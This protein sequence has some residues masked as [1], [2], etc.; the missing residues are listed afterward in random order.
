MM[1]VFVCS[2]IGIDIKD[3]DFRWTNDLSKERNPRLVNVNLT[4]SETELISVIGPVG[5][6]KST[7][8]HGI[9]GELTRPK[10]ELGIGGK[11]AYVPQQAFIINA[12][13]RDNILFGQPYIPLKYAYVIKACALQA[14]LDLFD[15]GDMTEIGE[16]GIN[17]SGGQ[18]QRISLARA[19]YDD[20]A[21]IILLDDPLSAVDAHVARH[22]FD[23]AINGLLKHKCRIFVTHSLQVI[24]QHVSIPILFLSNNE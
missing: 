12:S 5:S 14:D 7:L 15:N 17:I 6:G 8:L 18:K 1:S 22:L 16:R 3:A 20:E 19:C 2:D 4:A 10:G 13:I 23:L 11:I 24:D 9:L 21:D